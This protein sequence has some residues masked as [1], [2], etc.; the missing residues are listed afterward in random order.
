MQ[1]YVYRCV[2]FTFL[3]VCSLLFPVN[4]IERDFIE[5]GS[6]T[7]KRQFYFSRDFK[8]P[9]VLILN[10]FWT[11]F[12]YE[13]DHPHSFDSQQNEFDWTRDK[14]KFARLKNHD[15]LLYPSIIHFQHWEFWFFLS[16]CLKFIFC[17]LCFS[18]CGFPQIYSHRFH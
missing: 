11:F 5:A 1:K 7:E 3:N 15:H 12:W 8:Y 14:L 13:S 17:N 2:L 10:L 4:L 16:W 9:P 18:W 6:L